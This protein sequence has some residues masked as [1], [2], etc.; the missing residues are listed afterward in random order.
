MPLDMALALLSPDDERQQNTRP[1]EP[2]AMSPPS[3]A[4]RPGITY[5]AKR[6]KNVEKNKP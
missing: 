3:P 2:P 6:F 4:K 5:I 1:V